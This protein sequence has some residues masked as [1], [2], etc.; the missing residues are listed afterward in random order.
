MANH[1]N[2]WFLIYTRPN[3]EK[4]IS[5]ALTELKI[6]CFLPTRIAIKNYGG[7]RKCSNVPLFPSY[8]FVYI[9]TIQE[10]FVSL[11]LD[12]VLYYVKCG[13]EIVRVN[14]SVIQNIK[15]AVNAGNDLEVL[16]EQFQ[17][18]QLLSINKGP[19]TG[20]SGEIVQYKGT[21]KVLIRVSLLERSILVNLPVESL[22]HMAS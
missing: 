14:E 8:I 13:K 9:K 17:P 1:F 19:L 6:A 3:Q 11:A 18:G 21:K 15:L 22:G 20:M 16:S 4:R 7:K 5:I 12:G 2:G 10:Y